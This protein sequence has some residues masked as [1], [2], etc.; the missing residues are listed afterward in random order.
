VKRPIRTRRP[1]NRTPTPHLLSRHQCGTASPSTVFNQT[2][3]IAEPKITLVKTLGNP[4]RNQ[5]NALPTPSRWRHEYSSYPGHAVPNQQ[6]P[7]RYVV[8]KTRRGILQPSIAGEF[9]I[10]NRRPPVG[11]RPSLEATSGTICTSENRCSIANP[12]C[13]SQG[14]P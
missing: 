1:V 7:R 2:Y 3:L 9:G 4:L 13:A 5:N 11:Q 12:T 8:S 6:P 14:N 10:P